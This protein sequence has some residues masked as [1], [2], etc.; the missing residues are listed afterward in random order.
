MRRII[1]LESPPNPRL[2]LGQIFGWEFYEAVINAYSNSKKTF[3]EQ[4]EI[5]SLRGL[6][7]K[8]KFNDKNI[9]Y[10]ENSLKRSNIE[11]ITNAFSMGHHNTVH[12]SKNTIVRIMF[13]LRSALGVFNPAENSNDT[14]YSII[15]LMDN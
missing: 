1:A 12:L 15:A 11:L 3:S 7:Y 6:I 5:I 4:M 9:V 8:K 14:P 13:R 10:V 2:S